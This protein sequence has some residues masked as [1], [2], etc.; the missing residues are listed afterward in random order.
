[1]SIKPFYFSTFF[2]LF[3][4][5]IFSAIGQSYR[6]ADTSIVIENIEKGRLYAEASNDSAYFYLETALKLAN[7]IPFPKGISRSMSA[8]GHL[9]SDD[10]KLDEA[11]PYLNKALEIAE[12]NHLLKEKGT[13]NNNLAVVYNIEGKYQEALT[14]G[15]NNLDIYISL[16]DSNGI[17]MSYTNIAKALSFMNFFDEA[18]DYLFKSMA[19]NE[20]IG[21]PERVASRYSEIGESYLAQNNTQEAK[22][23]LYQSI[24]KFAK[25]NN[26]SREYTALFNLALCHE[27]E[28][29]VDSA[30][31]YYSICEKIGLELD[32]DE[33]LLYTWAGLGDIAIEK[34]DLAKGETLLKKSLALAEAAHNTQTIKDISISL[35]YLYADK[36]DYKNAFEFLKKGSALKDTLLNEDKI[37]EI[38]QISAKMQMNEIEM[39]NKFLKEENELQKLRL[40]R[41]NIL[42]YSVIGTAL[43]LCILALLL[44]RHNRMKIQQEQM[45][46]E[47][48]QLRSQMNPHFIFN[49]LNSIQHY[50]VYNDIK[51]ANKYLTE[52]ASLMRKTLEISGS[53]SISLVQEKEYLENYL[54][55]EQMRFENQFSYLIDID[56]DIDVNQIEIPPMI[57]QPFVENALR[58]GL[59]YLEDKKGELL[60]HFSYK[61]ENILCKIDDNGIGREKAEK[62]HSK[63]TKEHQSLGIDLTKQRLALMKKLKRLGY[64]LSIIDKYNVEGVAS[65]TQVIITIPQK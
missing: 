61:D 15:K 47:Q 36:K 51:N 31:Y 45:D 58:H 63:N 2:L 8:L 22:K 49:C 17:A 23:Y 3:C 56:K 24:Q 60:I 29:N 53:N 64:D 13:A 55:L 54:M 1:M 37:K 5:S 34:G 11:K 25:L 7:A 27:M 57:V 18:R 12:K 14:L 59:Q 46:L 33:I 26:P 9:Y 62:L 4:L 48:K 10:G 38:A 16:N 52:F 39:K 28:Q 50:M 41:K 44:Y 20:K 30:Y 21:K 65:G 19:I 40:F 42:L 35:S 6:L 43:F 32:S